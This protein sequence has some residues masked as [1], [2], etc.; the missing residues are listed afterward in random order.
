[1]SDLVVAC[2]CCMARGMVDLNLPPSAGR[3]ILSVSPID[4]PLPIP[5]DPLPSSAKMRRK[6]VEVCVEQT[7][8]NGSQNKRS[9]DMHRQNVVIGGLLLET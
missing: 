1:M 7:F 3:R 8:Q 9:T 2:N 4:L 6:T 5:E